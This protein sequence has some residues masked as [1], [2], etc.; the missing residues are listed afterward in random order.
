MESDLQGYQACTTFLI[1]YSHGNIEKVPTEEKVA[2]VIK[3]GISH[4][5]QFHHV[6]QWGSS[7][8][9][10]YKVGIDFNLLTN[11]KR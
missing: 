1:T 10:H 7:Q 5:K 11:T 9:K 3:N 4:R 8:G 6:L 2:K